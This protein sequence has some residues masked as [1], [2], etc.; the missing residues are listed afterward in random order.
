VSVWGHLD[1]NPVAVDASTWTAANGRS[2]DQ[3]ATTAHAL[4]DRRRKDRS[5]L[6]STAQEDPVR[7]AAARNHAPSRHVDES[8]RPQ[9][10]RA[11]PSRDDIAVLAEKR[12][13][14]AD[15]H[16]QDYSARAAN[17]PGA[18]RPNK[19]ECRSGGQGH[20]CG[21]G[22]EPAALTVEPP[23]MSAPVEKPGQPRAD[24]RVL[25]SKSEPIHVRQAPAAES[26]NVMPPRSETTSR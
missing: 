22:Q 17:D 24:V 19:G 3:Q 26:T 1:V 21:S 4:L 16:L 9:V 6:D 8:S 5:R 2:D 14:S 18:R 10:E 15:P 12:E 23:E 25:S 7:R 11:V 20:T 13:F